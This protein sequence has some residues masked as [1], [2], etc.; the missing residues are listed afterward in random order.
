MKIEERS[1]GSLT[2]TKQFVWCGSERCEERDASSAVTKQF[3]ATGQRNSSTNYFYNTDHL[4]SVRE[5]TNSSGVI[6]A[7][8]NYDPYG[9]VTKLQGS[10]DA[11]FQYAGYYVH[12]RSGLNLTVYRA[13]NPG[14]G[15]WISR[16]RLEE[17]GGI[18]LYGYVLNDPVSASDPLGLARNLK[19]FNCAQLAQLIS[20]KARELQKRAEDMER[21]DL[22]LPINDTHC[23][24]FTK[25]RDEL[26]RMISEYISRGCQG[27]LGGDTGKWKD[28]PTPQPNQDPNRFSN[29]RVPL[30]NQP[31]PV[32]PWWILL[33]ARAATR[34]I[35]RGALGW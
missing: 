3:F 33:G 27:P 2:S 32:V 22:G 13:Y 7:Q 25:Q 21:N 15:R 19:N 30:I 11:D 12:A 4:G 1:G 28:F 16:D 35:T 10:Q 8:Y 9:Q 31:T 24:E 14:L 29:P 17:S 34:V 20:D 6:Q 5:M 18:N 23:G 26:N